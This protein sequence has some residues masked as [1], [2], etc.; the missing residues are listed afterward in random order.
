MNPSHHRVVRIAGLELL[1]KDDTAR[2]VL[3]GEGGLDAA[4]AQVFMLGALDDATLLKMADGLRSTPTQRAHTTGVLMRLAQLRENYP[5][6]T[7]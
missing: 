5:D 7:R 4:A 3:R 6:I 2:E 1:T